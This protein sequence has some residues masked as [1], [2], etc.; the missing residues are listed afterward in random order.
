MSQKHSAFIVT[1]MTCSGCAGTVKRALEKIPGVS[2]AVVDHASGNVE[3]R[4]DRDISRKEVS[5]ALASY[6]S[7]NLHGGLEFW[8]DVG[9]WK[10]AGLNTLNCLIGCSI[11]DFGMIIF[12]QANYPEI[13][14]AVQMIMATISGLITSVALETFLLH[15]NEKMEINFAFRTAMSMSFISMVA[16]ELAMNTTDFMITGGAAAFS[17]AAYWLALIPSMVAG[18]IVP[19]PYNYFRLKKYNR[20][21][22]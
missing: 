1:G 15:Q 2:I 9:I 8:S 18:F 14:M 21:C 7:Y 3:L 5:L 16:M 20:A 4:A 22:H 17:S 10:R 13:G 19:L 12:L 6:P 11:G